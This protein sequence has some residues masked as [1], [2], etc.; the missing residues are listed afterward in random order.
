VC[1]VLQCSFSVG[2]TAHW[3]LLCLTAAAASHHKILNTDITRCCY[4][5]SE[6]LLLA[7]LAACSV[8]H[9]QAQLSVAVLAVRI[10]TLSYTT[11]T[12]ESGMRYH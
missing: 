6:A 5:C 4:A 1:V 2:L 9:K 8:K 11:A 12:T 10:A 3:P 7:S